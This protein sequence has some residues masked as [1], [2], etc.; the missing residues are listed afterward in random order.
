MLAD[1]DCAF[2]AIPA[3][4]EHFKDLVAVVQRER[5]ELENGRH[6][7]RAYHSR[8]IASR[9]GQ[10]GERRFIT[11][12]KKLSVLTLILSLP[13]IAQQKQPVS[14][15]QEDCSVIFSLTVASSG[16]AAA[17]NSPGTT[18]VIDNRQAG[19][20]DWIVTYA[21]TTTVTGISLLFQTATDVGG[22]PT[23]WSSYPGTLNSGSNPNT[24]VTSGGAVTDAT[25]AKYPF[26]RMNLTSLTGTGTVSGKLYGWKRRPTVVSVTSGGGC[27]G[28][29]ATPCVVVGPTAVGSPPATSPVL[30]AGQDGTNIRT[31][32][33]DTTGHPQVVGPTAAGIAPTFA[34][35]LVGGQDGGNIQIL[36]TDTAG[37]LQVAVIGNAAVLSGQQAV[38]GSAVALATHAAKNICVKAL[39]ANSL[40]VYVGPTG[41]TTATGMELAP[42]DSLCVPVSNSNLLFVIASTTG[43]SVSWASTN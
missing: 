1:L 15:M 10:T 20:I 21:T 41:V 30:T 37:N 9:T 38:T 23:T 39:I 8:A 22:V 26:L 34:P 6:P 40:N 17:V 4:N 7:N 13:L 5:F 33:T 18:P 25:G 11:S 36:K 3:D 32:K 28:S 42:G 29:I 12:M 24:V 2:V 14:S 43:A 27:P 16:T 31:I 19:C 35:V